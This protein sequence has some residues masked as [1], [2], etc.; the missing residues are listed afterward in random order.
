[1]RTG[2]CY[3]VLNSAHYGIV[4]GTDELKDKVEHLR[5]VQ[6]EGKASPPFSSSPSAS[7]TSRSSLSSRSSPP[8]S[9][10]PLP[11]S[12]STDIG[13]RLS[14]Q[15][16][17][18]SEGRFDFPANGSRPR[19][20]GKPVVTALSREESQA[21]TIYLLDYDEKTPTRQTLVL[22]ENAKKDGSRIRHDIKKCAEAMGSSAGGPKLLI[23]I[24]GETMAHTAR[25]EN[26]ELSKLNTNDCFFVLQTAL[27]PVVR[28]S[29][30][31]S[32]KLAALV[33]SH[34]EL[35]D[36]YRLKHERRDSV[37]S[38]EDTAGRAD[39]DDGKAE[40]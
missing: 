26:L 7:Y 14:H 6:N 39:D 29:P 11:S 35:L 20:P 27:Y 40:A 38:S 32:E 19:A 16:T 31:Y 2:N 5:Q 10:S 22:R 30:E 28:G 12:E 36:I 4:K 9:R 23:N 33:R 15:G 17:A 34:D 24:R 37:K 18:A 25:L 13:I 8:N 21:K 3:L 1:V